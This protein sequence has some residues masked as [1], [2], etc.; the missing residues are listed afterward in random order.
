MK[1]I[2]GEHEAYQYE[3]EIYESVESGG[4]TLT[5]VQSAIHPH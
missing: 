1:I 3:E 4:E 5:E 2:L